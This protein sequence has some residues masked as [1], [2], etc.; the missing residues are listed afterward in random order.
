MKFNPFHQ[1]NLLT[2]EITTESSVSSHHQ[3][4]HVS[5][6]AW[7]YHHFYVLDGVKAH[8]KNTQL[9][10]ASGRDR[11]TEEHNEKTM[12]LANKLSIW[13]INTYSKRFAFLPSPFAWL[14]LFSSLKLVKFRSF[15]FKL[16]SLLEKEF[17][18]IKS[19]SLSLIAITFVALLLFFVI[20]YGRQV[21]E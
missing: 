13:L 10:K 17:R 21:R 2:C 18:V 7:E 4:H 3:P 11:I 14:L 9:E 16:I 15:F 20:F 12:A 1:K 8:K 5:I 6:E 19:D